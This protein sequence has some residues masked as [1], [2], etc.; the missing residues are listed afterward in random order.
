MQQ[1]SSSSS[2]KQSVSTF[3]SSTRDGDQPPITKVKILFLQSH[4]QE[5]YFCNDVMIFTTGN[6][7][8]I[9]QLLSKEIFKFSSSAIGQYHQGFPLVF[10]QQELL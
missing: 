8:L 4:T 10:W 3:S 2:T 6:Y 7:V 9:Q 5:K 1:S